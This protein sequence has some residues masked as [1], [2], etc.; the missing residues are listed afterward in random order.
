MAKLPH[1]LVVP[2]P[3]QGHVMPLMEFSHQLVDHGAKVTFVNTE[4]IHNMLL[5]SLVDPKD[6]QQRRSGIHLVSVPDGLDIEEDRKLSKNLIYSM[7]NTMPRHLEDL[8]KKSESDDQKIDCVVADATVGWI[9]DVADKFGTKRAAFWPAS[10]AVLALTLHVPK[11]IEAGVIDENGTPMKEEVIRLPHG[12]PDMNAFKLMWESSSIPQMREIILKFIRTIS[13]AATVANWLICNSIDELEPISR[14]LVPS[15]LN[16]GPLLASDRLGQ[17]TGHF[18][19]EDSTCLAWLDQQPVHSVIYVAFGS[20]TIFTE[21][22]FNEIAHGLELVGK[23]YLWVVRPDITHELIP[24]F[25]DGFRDGVTHLGKLVAWAPQQKVLA[26]RSMACFLTHCGWNSTIEGLSLGVP[27]LCW[28][29]S[30]D[31]FHN[32]NFICD[33]L[34]VGLRL[35]KDE[36]GIITR[37]EIKVKVQKIYSDEQIRSRANKVKDMQKGV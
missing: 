12:M 11:L 26:H 34:N 30:A 36:N 10:L 22:Q 15:S 19:P 23:P 29:Y 9:F 32:Q 5:S 31:Q 2:F 37:D 17:P 18:W 35:N 14:D 27:L 4:Y 8:F 21:C 7:M 16:I 13:K 1:F 3:A 24:S 33:T 20:T 28:P 25:P 6:G